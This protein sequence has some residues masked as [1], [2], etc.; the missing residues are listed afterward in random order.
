[1]RLRSWWT[2][3]QPQT[4]VLE[5]K[6]SKFLAIAWPV[7]DV[8]QVDVQFAVIASNLDRL[9]AYGLMHGP[10]LFTY[11]MHLQAE[12]YIEAHK[13]VSASHNCYAY[14]VSQEQRASD[15]GEP[16]GTAGQPM[17]TA[18]NAEE[19]NGVCVLVTRCRSLL[20]VAHLLSLPKRY[21][22]LSLCT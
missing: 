19:L 15:D 8:S 10:L 14:K 5:V 6:K 12:Q 17:L 18:I 3:K 22:I 20:Q 16:S 1:M 13:D 4:T 11:P 9:F 21:K 2:L 7:T